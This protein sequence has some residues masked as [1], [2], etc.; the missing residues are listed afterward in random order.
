M[1]RAKRTRA[2]SESNLETLTEH[3]SERAAKR[4]VTQL[5]HMGHRARYY[6]PPE[7]PLTQTGFRLASVIPSMS[8]DE[9]ERIFAEVPVRELIEVMGTPQRES[10]KTTSIRIRIGHK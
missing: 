4:L 2:K 5:Q 7:R 1:P 6:R 8:A 3:L 10:A 9:V